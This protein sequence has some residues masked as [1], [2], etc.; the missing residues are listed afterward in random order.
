MKYLYFD[1][2]GFTGNNLLDNTQ[3]FFC[4]LGLDS[5]ENIENEFLNIKKHYG[6]S[7]EEIK[8]RNLSKTHNGQKL[9]KTLW[10]K[11]ANQAKYVVHDKKYALAAKMFEYTYEPVFSD[12]NTLLYKSGF[13]L[14]IT[15]FLYVNFRISDKTAESMF[16]SFVNF[17]HNKDKS[18]SMLNFTGTKPEKDNPMNCFYDFCKNNIQRI[19]NEIDFT[20]PV[21]RWLLDLTDTSLYS[22]LVTFA[23]NNNEEL[24]A[25]CDESKPLLSCN[26]FINAFIGDKRILYNDLLG[27]KMRFNFNLAKQIE[28]KNSTNCLSI[29]ITDCLVSSIYY[30]MLHKNEAFSKNI[31]QLS[32]V[33]FDGEH[34]VLPVANGNVFSDN[35]TS[36]NLHLLKEL[37][38][39]ITMEKKYEIIRK[40]SFMMMKL[41]YWER[42]E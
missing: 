22:L 34:S 37:S 19:E 38:R 6:Y 3:P 39:K 32:D 20:T 12:I 35:E 28:F 41:K 1:E 33:A 31:L 14:F 16:K 30:A 21:E 11:F 8:G 13:H 18:T 5:S 23:E 2:A 4:Y 10:E 24:Y 15:M 7:Y 42:K 9:I 40:Y 29:Q 27:K 26:D 36:L 17:I 25:F